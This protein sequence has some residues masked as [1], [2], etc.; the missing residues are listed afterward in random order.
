MSSDEIKGNGN[1][2]AG[3]LDVAF[4]MK[5]VQKNIA[6]FGGDPTKVTITGESAGGGA[7]MLLATSNNGELGT[8]LFQN[9]IAASPYRECIVVVLTSPDTNILS[10]GTVRLQRRDTAEIV[11]SV[12]L[13]CRLWKLWACS[14][15]PPIQGQPNPPA[16]QCG[17]YP[18]RAL[19]NMAFR[20]RHRYTFLPFD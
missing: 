1:P 10:P 7:V 2:N 13:S 11:L 17:Y 4:A 16:S 3:L 15:M 18:D 6:K 14:G 12:C 20:P 8:S 9:G 19:W 5:W